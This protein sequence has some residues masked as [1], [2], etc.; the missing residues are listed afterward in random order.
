VP[1]HRSEDGLPIGVMFT[2]AW[3]H[4]ALLLKLALSLEESAPWPRFADLA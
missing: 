3:G 1:L 2:A 4:D